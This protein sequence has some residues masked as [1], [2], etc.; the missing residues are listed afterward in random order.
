MLEYNVL[1]NTSHHCQ[2]RCSSLC[3]EHIGIDASGKIEWHKIIGLTTTSLKLE[4][5]CCC[6]LPHQE[7]GCTR[8]SQ[9]SVPELKIDTIF[10]LKDI[11]C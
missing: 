8:M 7:D 2:C 11:T 3:P 6:Y 9:I 10:H 1:W 5:V 4:K